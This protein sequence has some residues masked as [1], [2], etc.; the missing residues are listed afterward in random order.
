MAHELE[1]QDGV[2]SMAF[3]GETPW[4]HL[5]KKIPADLT[6]DQICVEAGCDWKVIKKPLQVELNG[7]HQNIKGNALVRLPNGKNV[8]EESVL[9]ILPSG[10]TWHEHQNEEAFAF[11]NDF[12]A[13]GDMTMETAGSLKRGTFVWAL[14][15]V[16]ESFYVVKKKD[17]VQSYLLFT[18]PHEFGKAIDVRFTPIRVV[19]NNTL[20]AALD[21]TTVQ[22]VSSSHRNPF[23]P[24]AVKAKLGLASYKLGKYKE[25]AQF[26][27]SKAY[28]PDAMKK[29]FMTVFPANKSRAAEDSTRERKELHKGAETALAI[30]EIQ[31]GHDVAPGTWWNA[32]NAATFYTNH[33]AGKSDDTRVHSLFYGD[34]MKM[35]QTALDAAIEFANDRG[36]EFMKKFLKTPVTA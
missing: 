9:T 11:F 7:S 19:C 26:L 13:S 23:D 17:E 25:A 15:R 22:R 14:A 8:K 20:C 32:F 28:T 27:A 4:H 34:A 21:S 31:P 10:K 35:N 5:G 18:N 2:A 3:N 16:K 33:L 12:V 29:Y 36:D 24:D 6:P 1:I 30:V